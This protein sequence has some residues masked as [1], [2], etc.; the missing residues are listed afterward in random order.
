MSF[1]SAT[2]WWS[3]G[4]ERSGRQ[5]S[6][7]SG[8]SPIAAPATSAR[9]VAEE[10][11]RGRR[12]EEVRR[13]LQD[14]GDLRLVAF[15]RRLDRHLHR[16]EQEVE[17]RRRPLA[18]GEPHE[19]QPRAVARRARRGLAGT[20]E[21]EEH[22]DQ[23]VPRPL[24]LRPQ[25][26]DQHLEGQVLMGE[27]G[28][29]RVAHRREQAAEGRIAGRPRPDH[30]R[31]D[32]EP[33]QPLDLRPRAVGDR[34]ADEQV[35][36]S[37]DAREERREAGEE[38]HV[39]RRPLSPRRLAESRRRQAEHRA[40]AA[41][42]RRRRALPVDRQRQRRGCPRELVAPVG[43]L[44]PEHLRRPG[45]LPGGEVGVLHGELAERRGAPREGRRVERRELGGQH[46][47]GPAVVDDVVK[48][49]QERVLLLVQAHQ[50]GPQQGAAGEAERPARLLG[51]QARELGEPPLPPEG[52]QVDLRQ[53][54][55][56]GSADLLPGLAVH[57]DEPGAQRLVPADDLG[58]AGGER[59]R[60]ERPGETVGGGYVVE[61]ALRRQ[62]V[63][64]P[65]PLL[66]E[67]ERRR[68]LPRDLRERRQGA[69]RP[70]PRRGDH[71]RLRGQGG[72]R[73]DRLRAE[74]HPERL[75]DARQQAHDGERMPAQVEEVVVGADPPAPLEGAPLERQ[76]AVGGRPALRIGVEHVLP[77]PGEHLQRPDRPGRS[78]RGRRR[79]APWPARPPPVRAPRVPAAPAGRAC[80]RR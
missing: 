65:E 24:A 37:R 8:D 19:V 53:R 60:R 26:L 14:Q 49:E 57:L 29:R 20:L 51:A 5:E 76:G 70:P 55:P 34:R 77:E 59:R 43:E 47:L 22:L 28:E 13:V 45:A 50:A 25:L 48:V 54:H 74:L 36:T 72:E 3:S 7:S 35:L 78:H 12:G 6:G 4:A 9:V 40:R 80:R 63:E 67:G 69:L 64:E 75:A 61:R 71:A 17:L 10:A 38:Q 39:E 62:A 30:H 16:R 44:P 41:E 31:V 2:S 73:E 21:G 15:S 79:R 52:A 11:R 58:E 23:G 46:P 27:G 56:P 1:H 42:A 68:P 33:D 32:E 66:G 18:P